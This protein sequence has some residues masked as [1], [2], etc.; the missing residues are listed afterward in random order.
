[1]QIRDMSKP[2]TSKALNETMAKKFG[3]KIDVESFTLEQLQDARNKIRTKQFDIETNESFSG[4]SQNRTYSKNKLF[5]DVLN[6]AISERAD[7]ADSALAEKK[8]KDWNK[9]GKNDWEDVKA[10]R[11]AASAK[12]K[13]KTDEGIKLVNPKSG[14]KIDITKPE[15]DAEY[16]KAKAAGDF[17]DEEV[18]EGDGIYHDCA[19]KFE[20]KVYGEC[21]VIPGEHTLLEDGTVTHYDATFVKEGETYIVRNVAVKDMHNVISEGH[22]HAAKSKRKK[23]KMESIIKE[24]AED[25]A[26][27]VMA[28]K[29]MVDRLTGWMED[30]AEMQT[31]SMLELADAIRDEMGAQQSEGFTNAVKPALEQL[32]AAMESTRVALTQ[33]VGM[34]TGEGEAPAA[35]MGAEE[36][37][38]GAEDMEP[39]VDDEFATDEFA[40]AAPAAGGEAEA[41]RERRESRNFAKKKMIETSRRLGSILSS[42]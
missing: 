40:A 34:L 21:T 12:G 15:G 30:T 25:H 4:L 18:K 10:A 7:V 33:G 13:K 11:M 6:A 37:V 19:K 41:G 22:T 26:E 39:T 23:A 14:K 28:A 17:D 3:T 27:L 38:P 1:M 24:G 42:R 31:E 9:D 36:P 32:Y 29:D 5:L 2:L 20:H 35:D 8:Q 16:K